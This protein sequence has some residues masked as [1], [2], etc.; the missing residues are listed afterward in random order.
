MKPDMEVADA[1]QSSI[2]GPASGTASLQVAPA[3]PPDAGDSRRPG[4][5]I[6]GP[7]ELVEEPRLVSRGLSPRADSAPPLAN[8]ELPALAAEASATDP[9]APAEVQ[10]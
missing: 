1:S 4:T 10:R 8:P 5:A 6:W 7:R 3:L 2:I 9:C